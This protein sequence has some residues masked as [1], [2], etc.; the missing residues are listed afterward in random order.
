MPALAQ[1]SF[2]H[3]EKS[4][5]RLQAHLYKHPAEA[6]LQCTTALF[7]AEK[8]YLRSKVVVICLLLALCGGDG[9]SSGGSG[10]STGFREAP[11]CSAVSLTTTAR[12]RA[13]LLQYRL[14]HEQIE[15]VR[16]GREKKMRGE[17][18]FVRTDTTGALGCP[19]TPLNY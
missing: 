18:S 16:R 15:R 17:S 10:M 11:A 14:S 4:S 13:C 3:N 8:V 2:K 12:Q 9:G 7:E 6:E 1:I 5:P 19:V